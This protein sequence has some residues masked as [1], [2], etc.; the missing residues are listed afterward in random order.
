MGGTHVARLKKVMSKH[1]YIEWEGSSTI[2]MYSHNK[3][4]R[5][6]L[7]LIGDEIDQI[8]PLHGSCKYQGTSCIGWMTNKEKVCDPLDV[9]FDLWCFGKGLA[10]NPHFLVH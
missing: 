7:S 1:P 9:Q 4:L 8:S 3:V 10:Y 2:G 6:P 5:W